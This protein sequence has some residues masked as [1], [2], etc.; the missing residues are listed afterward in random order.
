MK[1]N[2]QFKIRLAAVITLLLASSTSFAA[3]KPSTITP[4]TA[5]APSAS[6]DVRSKGWSDP[7]F[8]DM[9]WTHSCKWGSFQAKKGQK[10]KIVM[11]AKEVGMHPAATVWYRGVA[12]TAP[13]IYVVDT[14]YPQNA[15]IVKYGITD[16]DTGASLG[17]VVMLNMVYGY[18][19]DGNGVMDKKL[20]GKKDGVNGRLILTFT[21]P[22]DGDYSLV[23][24]GFNPDTNIDTT[25][26]HK[27]DV[28]LTVK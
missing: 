11:K 21:A 17:D 25:V 26:G 8:G 24:G 10:V 22:E 4:F 1:I 3:S 14:F 7:A 23:V 28:T 5:D 6:F 9:G 18:D 12:D 13:D 27:V 2:T 19:A 16:N 15:N 20:H